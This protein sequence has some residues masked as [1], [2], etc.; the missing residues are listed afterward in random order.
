METR[1]SQLT[2]LVVVPT[3]NFVDWS[4]G[5]VVFVQTNPKIFGPDIARSILEK[6]KSIPSPPTPLAFVPRPREPLA[7][8]VEAH[9]AWELAVEE[10]VF[11][12][13]QE[14]T[15]YDLKM[16]KHQEREQEFEQGNAALFGYIKS[17]LSP[18]SD[19][20][21]V[22]DPLYGPAFDDQDGLQ[23]YLLAKE[24]CGPAASA[25]KAGDI[26]AELTR[27]E[28]IKQQSR[29]SIEDFSQRFR[30]QLKVV[31]SVHPDWDSFLQVRLFLSSVSDSLRPA[32][33]TRET[34]GAGFPASFEEAAAFLVD[35]E[36]NSSGLRGL[37]KPPRGADVA[38]LAK[39]DSVRK[40]SFGPCALCKAKGLPYDHTQ[41]EK[42]CPTLRSTSASTSKPSGSKSTTG[43]TSS[44]KSLKSHAGKKPTKH[45]ASTAISSIPDVIM[46]AT[47][48]EPDEP[49]D[50][51]II[52]T[53][54]ISAVYNSMFTNFEID[55]KCTLSDCGDTSSV[56]NTDFDNTGIQSCDVA[57]NACVNPFAVLTGSDDE[58]DVNDDDWNREIRGPLH[59]SDSEIPELIESDIFLEVL[60]ADDNWVELI[61]DR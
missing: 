50:D 18:A 36:K 19:A 26:S 61:L 47:T 59:D 39:V 57:L 28:S 40:V 10:H 60:L 34:T 3:S 58:S 48:D 53:Y 31:L 49:D 9:E 54:G 16:K 43:S 13:A 24:F 5:L 33:D 17:H 12:R 44:V 38:H 2:T 15:D 4:E 6:E 20:R 8:D 22:V 56:V 35:Y 51:N 23:L 41:S 11:R 7:A 14:K 29:E 46:I 25:H 27:L 1:K 37:F 52:E 30:K 21:V 55:A 45:T 42:Y 32:V